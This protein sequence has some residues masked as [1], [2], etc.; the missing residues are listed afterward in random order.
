[1][2]CIRPINFPL[3]SLLLF[4]I[5]C[6]DGNPLPTGKIDP[7]FTLY[8]DRFVQE[9]QLRNVTVDMGG[10]SITSKNDFIVDSGGRHCGETSGSL[11]GTAVTIVTNFDCWTNAS[12]AAK[13]ILIFHELGH[14]LLKRE[15]NSATFPNTNIYKSIMNYVTLS[16]LYTKY[17]PDKRKYYI[18][19]L[20]DKNTPAPDWVQERTNSKE[21]LN[22]SLIN[23]S[24][25][26]FI[27]PGDTPSFLPTFPWA[28]N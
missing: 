26:E 10:F 5:S 23:I 28:R 13:E 14:A 9:A 1:M 4:A 6:T 20:F 17:T 25:W 21:I 16:D 18:D 27:K 8:V 19:E 22:D 24:G 2:R 15:H 11:K 7:E 12:E 3:Y